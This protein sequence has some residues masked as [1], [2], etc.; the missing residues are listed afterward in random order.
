MST[1]IFFTNHQ[2]LFEFH[3]SN[4]RSLIGRSDSC[5]IA[6]PGETLSRVHCLIEQ[7]GMRWFLSDQSRHGTWVN[8]ERVSRVQLN[9]K[10]EFHIGE[11]RVVF[12]LSMR[13]EAVTTKQIK[14]EPH[15]FVTCA[16][17]ELIVTQAVLH[18]ESGPCADE[19]FYLNSSQVTVGGFGSDIVLSEQLMP[20]HC[21]LRV[22]RGR[23]MVEPGLGPVFLDGR[24][25]QDITPLYSDE[26][27][28]IGAIQFRVE[29]LSLEDHSKANAFGDML[30]E[31]EAMHTIFG[32][33]RCFAAHDFPI[34]ILGE[35]GTG[36]ELAA[37]G[38]HSTSSRRQGPFVVINCGAIPEN[39]LES[40]L[41][42]HVKGAFTGAD[43]DRPGAFQDADGGTLFL[44]ELGEMSE[45]MQVKL[46]RVLESG[47]V[48]PVGANRTVYPDVRIV[49]AT[50]VDL[51]QAVEE[52]RFRADLF[53]RLSVLSIQLPALRERPE[54]IPLLAQVML[55]RLDPGFEITDGA[56]L[57]LKAYPW[58][59]NVRELRNVISRA[60]VLGHN[61][62]TD[63]EIR[64]FGINKKT[65]RP[66]AQLSSIEAE[67]YY[68]MELMSKHNGNRAA[69]A[70]DIGVAR[71][72]L[73][74]RMRRAGLS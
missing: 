29:R 60:F 38:I 48:R 25:I 52:G 66:E 54:D 69:M 26:G 50:N 57:M 30:G 35:S 74:Y 65:S 21:R 43:S 61:P 10:D 58:P 67:R 20:N 46:L 13:T 17:D 64:F 62:I 63:S 16:S 39:L 42:G 70:R 22:S 12:R 5:D 9:D 3:I 24:R 44:D 7:R 1:L 28:R 55:S 34:L 71:T 40:E 36:K 45:A 2:Q 72:T 37:N 11:Y 59:G 53:F 47:E 18:V 73:L 49:A 31:S 6:L 33:L 23:A 4:A 8:G 51:H 56:L 14:V 19:V 41:F 27:V 32:R 15:K 68:L